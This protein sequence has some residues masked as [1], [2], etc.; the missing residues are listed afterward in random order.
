[1]ISKLWLRLLTF[2]ALCVAFVAVT[3]PSLAT[4]AYDGRCPVFVSSDSRAGHAACGFDGTEMQSI[5]EN[6]CA[7]STTLAIGSARVG[8]GTRWAT[9]SVSTRT[10][11][12]P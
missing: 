5:S 9:I 1:M 12:T 3:P 4:V 2:L 8:E 11:T 10:R 6:Y 7:M